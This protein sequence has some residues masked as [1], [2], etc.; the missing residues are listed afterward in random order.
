MTVHTLVVEDSPGLRLFG[1]VHNDKFY[2][3]AWKLNRVL[4]FP[5]SRA[6]DI[7]LVIS[8]EQAYF[9]R[10]LAFDPDRETE[11]MLLKNR[12][13]LGYLIQELRQ[14]DFFLIE[15]NYDCDFDE[16]LEDQVKEAGI[17]HMIPLDYENLRPQTRVNLEI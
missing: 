6:E 3:T 2:R 1:M 5:L 17:D 8:G 11:I 4:P 12:G 9:A 16:E 15:R 14:F 10:Y 7:H 13:T